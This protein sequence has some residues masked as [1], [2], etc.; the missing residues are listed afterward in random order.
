M[1]ILKT[2]CGEIKGIDLGDGVVAYKGI[3]YARAK[4]FGYPVEVSSWDGV[5]DATKYGNCAYQPRSFY[6]EEEVIELEKVMRTY[7]GKIQRS[8]GSR[9]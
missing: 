6:N 4:R 8:G 5:Y 3:R 2:K 9:C 7:Y 1:E